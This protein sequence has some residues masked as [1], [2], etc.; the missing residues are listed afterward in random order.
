MVMAEMGMQS[1]VSADRFAEHQGIVPG[2][3]RLARRDQ[4][5]LDL[6]RELHDTVIQPITSLLLS[7]TRLECQPSSTGEVEGHLGMWKGLA[8]EA[9][10]SLRSSLVGLQATSSQLDDLPGA[11]RCALGSHLGTDGLEW[12]V[13]SHDWPM[14]LPPTWNSNLYLAVRE[15][16]TNA[17]KHAQASRVSVVLDAGDKALT[18]TVADDGVGI[19]SADLDSKQ[20]TR[21]GCGLGMSSIRDRVSKLGGELHLTSV[22][23][24]GV[25][26]EIRLPRPGHVDCMAG[27]PSASRDVQAVCD[28]W[29]IH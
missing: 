17:R 22:R 15:A 11:L 3:D 26:I 16:V 1:E 5:R 19:A 21:P 4:V 27:P 2:R 20:S 13:E 9:L 28:S 12:N 7:I 23:G 24:R 25:R 8:Q 18:I 29:N 6:A 10:D 14:D